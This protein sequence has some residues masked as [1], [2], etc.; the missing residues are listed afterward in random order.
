[1]KNTGFNNGGGGGASEAN[2]V[3]GVL[4][5]QLLHAL[6][7]L[8]HTPLLG[9]NRLLEHLAQRA[10]V[11]QLLVQRHVLLG[12]LLQRLCQPLDAPLCVVHNLLLR[13]HMP[14]DACELCRCRSHGSSA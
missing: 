7:Q 5:L 10:A 13:Q 12:L 11:A 4:V 14:V 2:S 8:C 3:S 6:L 9:V 1:M